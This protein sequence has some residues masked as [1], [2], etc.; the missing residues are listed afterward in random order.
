MTVEVRS[1][2]ILGA[3]TMGTGIAQVAAQAGISATLVDTSENSIVASRNRLGASLAG[4]VDRGK[5]T[6]DDAE[7]ARQRITW[8]RGGKSLAEADWVIEAVTED[9]A[10]KRDV[11][12]HASA[13]AG[14][15]T[16]IAT[17]TSTFRI[18]DLAA[19]CSNPRRFLG[20][21]FFNPPPAMKLVEVIP[22]AQTAPEVTEAAVALCQRLGKT[23]VM[24]PDVPGFL[25]NRVFAALVAAAA[26]LWAQG[27]DPGTVDQAVE[28][29]LAH[30]LG[31]LRS[32]DLVGLDVMLAIL[33]SLYEQTGDRRFAV[34]DEFVKL[35]ESG[36]IGRKSGEGFY[37][38]A[39]GGR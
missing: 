20:L 37:R 19:H 24:A 29:G 23:P 34:R 36:K 32:A 13:L 3:G 16:P 35:V 1:L 14:S 25:V 28:L 31:P 33:R 17:N 8:S 6:A 11:L 4:G 38:Y 2:Y 26:D 15:G 30:K 18:R 9:L 10:V 27:A 7:A 12:V 5:L 39:E 22:G 21:H